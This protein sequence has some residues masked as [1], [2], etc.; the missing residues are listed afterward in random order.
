MALD[1]LKTTLTVNV[2]GELET[3]G[4][5]DWT[6]L[7]DLNSYIIT[8]PALVTTAASS[9]TGTSA[10][11]GGNAIN[12]NN[13]TIS[14]KGVQWS[15]TNDFA[16]VL[17]TTNDGTGATNYSSALTPLTAGTTYYARAYAINEAGTGYGNTISFITGTVPSIVTTTPYNISTT[18]ADSGGES[19]SDG[20]LTLINKGIEWSLNSS[21]DPILNSFTVVTS[22]VGSFTTTMPNLLA[23]T[24]YYVRA[25]ATNSLGV[26]Y[27]A[28]L[29]FTTTS[30]PPIPC[31]SAVSSGGEGITDYSVSL[32]PNGGLVAFLFNA[33]SVVDKF[34][35]IH[36][37]ANG[38]KV[39]T[40]GM[41][42]SNAGPFD[43][44]YG[45]EPTNIVPTF[46]QAMAVTQF[47][48]ND[49]GPCSTRQA[50]FTSETSYVVNSMT[51]GYT[52]YQQVIWWEYTAADYNISSLA[53]ARVT[54]ISGTGWDLI[55]LC[56]PDGNCAAAPSSR[57][58]VSLGYSDIDGNTSCDN[59]TTAPI[60]RYLASGQTWVNATY[61]Y[62]DNTTSTPA[63]AGWYSDGPKWRYWTQSAFTS[64]AFCGT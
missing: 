64:T 25:F 14:A 60:N 29:P 2:G 22:D 46:S 42:G 38:N 40:T 36:G 50:E 23:D 20:S 44:T 3:A 53:T 9:I 35:I 62:L 56:C 57:E 34:E 18:S 31:S 43:D 52:T 4:T 37:A 13:G 30:T 63:Q 26:S 58:I 32:N 15:I 16:A 48:G 1:S 41:T 39:A 7:L 49:K 17:G 33:Q 54:G 24:T 59:F 45:T 12:A 27:G 10:L 55:R 28:I 19:I 47:I 6:S 51:I 8:P 21:M 61:L 5:V 11:S